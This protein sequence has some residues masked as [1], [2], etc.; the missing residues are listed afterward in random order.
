[1][2]VPTTISKSA[3]RGVKRGSAAPKRSMSYR[4]PDT[5]KNSIPQHAVTNG[6]GKNEYLRAQFTTS[7]SRV[8][9]NASGKA[10]LSSTSGCRAVAPLITKLAILRRRAI[11]NPL[12]VFRY[13]SDFW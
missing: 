13:L 11:K 9:A 10:L 3:W 8:V 7:A 2:M 4:G 5:E 12:L 1:V 6:K